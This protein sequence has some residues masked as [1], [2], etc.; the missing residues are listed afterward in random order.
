MVDDQDGRFALLRASCA[1]DEDLEALLSEINKV[2][3]DP[4]THLAVSVLPKTETARLCNVRI[5][6][7]AVINDAFS[8]I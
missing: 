2:S 3:L 4:A 5:E 6:V 8:S 7:I 1:V